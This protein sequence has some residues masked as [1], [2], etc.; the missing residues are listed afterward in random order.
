MY[1]YH[2]YISLGSGWS[3]VVFLSAWRNSL[4]SCL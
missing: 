3:P 4:V 2:I 1:I